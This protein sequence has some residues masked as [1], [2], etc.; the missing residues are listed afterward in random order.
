MVPVS[1][2]PVYI[3]S[4]VIKHV[5]VSIM[6]LQLIN[7]LKATMKCSACM[8]STLTDGLNW[9]LMQCSPLGLLPSLSVAS[10][11]VFAS[12]V[13]FLVQPFY[14]CLWKKIYSI[15]H[16]G[17]SAPSFWSQLLCVQ[18]CLWPNGSHNCTTFYLCC[19]SYG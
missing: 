11:F 19:T 6:A 12:H 7:S 5:V 17:Y 3:F 2:S 8:Y 4:V 10:S 15:H 13:V 14:C 1:Y 9:N 16:V 18:S